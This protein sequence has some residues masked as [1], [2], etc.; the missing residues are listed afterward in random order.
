[1]DVFL[2]CVLVFAAVV[3]FTYD[4]LIRPTVERRLFRRAIGRGRR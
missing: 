2:A 1:M 3:A 4:P